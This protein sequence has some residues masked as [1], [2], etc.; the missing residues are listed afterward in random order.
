MNKEE[1]DLQKL[2]RF[3]EAIANDIP[4]DNGKKLGMLLIEKADGNLN[5]LIISLASWLIQLDFTEEEALAILMAART[6][7][8][9][10]IFSTSSI[11]EELQA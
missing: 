9:A 11:E 3:S 2:I 7:A 1:N 5:E 6:R 10:I 8:F 4:T